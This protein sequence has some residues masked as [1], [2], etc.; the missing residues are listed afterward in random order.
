[1]WSTLRNYE[2]DEKDAVRIINA[3]QAAFYWSRGIQPISIYPSKDFKTDESILV[4]IFQKS[5]TQK[6]YEEWCERKNE[7]LL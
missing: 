1:M 5:T 2:Y 6:L 7:P 3:K 4:F